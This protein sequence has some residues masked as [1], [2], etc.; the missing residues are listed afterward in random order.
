M[1]R[2]MSLSP[3][4]GSAT[5]DNCE[6]EQIHLAG[7]I[8]PHGALLVLSEP[9]LRVLQ[10]SA[11]IAAFLPCSGASCVGLT[12]EALA[13]SLVPTITRQLDEKLEDIVLA[14]RCHGDDGTKLDALLHRPKPGLLI[15]ELER[16]GPPITLAGPVEAAL[17]ALVAADS[18][19]ALC[20]EAAWVFRQLTGYDRV[21]VY[22]F[23]EEGH[24]AV[25][26]EQRRADLEA[27]LGN[28]YPATDIPHIARKLYERNR[29]R[30]LVDVDYTPVPV[31]PRLT[32]LQDGTESELDMSLCVLR[33]TSPIHLQYLKNMGVSATLVVSLMVDGRLWGLISCH[34]YTKRLLHFEERAVC[35]LLAETVSTRITALEGFVQSQVELSVRRIEQRIIESITRDGDWRTCLFDG[36]TSLLTP[37]GASGAALLFEGQCLTLGDVPGTQRLREIAA[38]LDEHPHRAQVYSTTALGT[39][40]PRFLPIAD[41]ASGLL[42]TTV[43]NSPGEYLL[44]FRHEQVQDITWGGNPA[45]AVVVG[46]T[47]GD[48][49]PRRS[50]AQWHQRVEGTSQAWTQSELTAA[51]LIGETVMD[52]VLQFRA[53]RLLIA[54]DQLGEVSRQVVD[55][56]QPVLIADESGLL[57]M[58]N[59]A[60]DQLLP[61]QR[62][63]LAHLDDLAELFHEPHDVRRRLADLRAAHRTWRGEVLLRTG[64][65][66]DRSMLVRADPVFSAP[67]RALGYVLLFTDLT[68]RKQ[69][70]HARRL[71]QERLAGGQG[72]V[73]ARLDARA[74]MAAQGLLASV[75]E[76]A[77]LAALEIT[78]GVDTGSMARRLESVRASVQRA[79]EMLERLIRHA[80]QL[81]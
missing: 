15:V 45:E 25:V 36:S 7:S 19:A 12:L 1:L 43:S 27:L 5:L 30:V 69:A 6:R 42:A 72:A 33:S 74:G 53:V 80:G 66:P 55:S 56:E 79:T 67:G 9:D 2:H 21:M 16:A 18:L 57:L 81:D 58:I 76:N 46:A 77:Q 59:H 41:V 23:D 78:D 64:N 17:K 10:A 75:L 29:V 63:Q 40:A 47:P 65:G 26:A 14:V 71:F 3:G 24:G 8:Q 4:F 54:Q 22:R 31:V 61:L 44:W 50:F 37:L 52:V 35:E 28:R 13:P 60:F 32:R 70:D 38:W 48:L 51:R 39:D 11:N 73:T 62:P 34:H 68:E 49:S 20:D